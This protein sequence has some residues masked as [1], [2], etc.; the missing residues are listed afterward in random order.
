MMN[1][2][3]KSPIPYYYQLERILRKRIISGK[4]KPQEK[5]PTERELC[6]E[7]KVSRITVRQA[8]R[9]LENAGLITR[10]QGQ[11]TFVTGQKKEPAL[12]ELYGFVDDIFSQGEK[13]TLKLLHKKLIKADSQIAQDMGL[14]EGTNIFFFEGLRLLTDSIV[15]FFQAYLP[16]EVGAKIR[17][18]K[19]AS[20]LLIS[21]VEKIS[22]EMVQKAQ[23]II[24]ATKASKKLAKVMKI[25]IGDPLLV[26]KRIYFSRKGKVLEVAITYF[27]GTSY[28][29]IAKLEKILS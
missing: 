20:P 1:K 11:G 16:Q 15:A 22:L 10:R 4:L 28:Q 18:K 9:L 24:S 23:Q 14:L 13:S 26:V 5:F 3:Q 17:L 7:F 27:P 8:L 19:L 6:A 29:L 12:Y 25:K 21:T 2:L